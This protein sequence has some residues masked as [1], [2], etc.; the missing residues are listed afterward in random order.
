[1]M[2]AL[3]CTGGLQ[4]SEFIPTAVLSSPTVNP[5]NMAAACLPSE[6]SRHNGSLG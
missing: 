4:S 3:D 1:M 6:G 5:S 2:V